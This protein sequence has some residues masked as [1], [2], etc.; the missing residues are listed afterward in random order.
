MPTRQADVYQPNPWRYAGFRY[1]RLISAYLL[2]AAA[3]VALRGLGAVDGTVLAVLLVMF[4]VAALIGEM[5]RARVR[6]P[7]L[8]IR[9]RGDRVDGPAPDLGQRASFPV[10]RV[11]VERTMRPDAWRWLTGRYTIWSLDGESIR[12]EA[13]GF[14]PE[15]VRAILARIGCN[16]P[17]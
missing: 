3:G 12:L 16:P 14:S 15:D 10:A 9:F 4:A 13:S 6:V 7:A 8:Y 11:D 5:L 17:E 1:V 2:L